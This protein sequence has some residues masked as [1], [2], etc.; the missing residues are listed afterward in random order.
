MKQ[1]STRDWLFSAALVAAV[2]LAYWPAWRG[3]FWPA[4]Q[5]TFIWDDDL[6]LLNN[7]VLRPGGLVRT[8][9]PGTY[10][11]YW[12][13][14]CTV[15][16]IE[17]QLWGLSP[18]GFH[19]VNIALHALSAILVW[20]V[21]R[22]LGVP[23]ALL[24]AALFALHPVNVESV[25]WIT[26]LKNTLSLVLT[27]LSRAA[28]FA[29]RGRGPRER[30]AAP[31][32]GGVRGCCGSGVAGACGLHRAVPGA[33]AAFALATLA[34][35]MT[36][37]LPVVLLA[38]AWW[39]RGRIERRDLLRVVPFLLIGLIM[40]GMEVYQQHVSAQQ[41]VVR[42]D[43]LLSR[44]AVAGCAVWF[45][46]WKLIWPVDLMF[47]Y[48]RWDLAAVGARGFCRGCCWRRFWRRPGGGGIPGGG[49]C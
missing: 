37:T 9:V 13:L 47:V 35:G 39:Q 41:T 6:H 44:T 45:Y 5:G 12:P 30:T 18:T 38:C 15:Y 49:R 34:K 32:P 25:A 14:T 23:G 27:L 22:L 46:L 8:W 2:F 11:I 17:H 43:G 28:V 29:R 20:R 48:P 21:L 24:A 4:R 7:P 40:V 36:L 16:W 3:A 31:S 33:V 19:L 10:V 26:Q 42:T 1:D